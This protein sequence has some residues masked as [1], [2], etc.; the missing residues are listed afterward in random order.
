MGKDIDFKLVVTG[1]S[2]EAARVV[3]GEVDRLNRLKE[4]S[5]R[6]ASERQ[7]IAQMERRI[8]FNSLT[9]EQRI[10]RLKERQLTLEK[11][12]AKARTDGNTHRTSAISTSLA[13]TRFDLGQLISTRGARLLNETL[14]S[15]D[16]AIRE[17]AS[18]DAK[19]KRQAEEA[20]R[21]QASRDARAKREQASRDAKAKRLAEDAAARRKKLPGEATSATMDL[22]GGNLGGF[23]P[24]GLVVGTL[25]ASVAGIAYALKRGF[26]NAMEF[27][28][29]ISDMADLIGAS[30]MDVMRMIKASGQAGVRNTTVMNG[31]SS[32]AAARG[33][34]LSGDEG[35][36]QLFQRYGIGQSV[37]AGDTSN[38]EIGKAIVRS[39][40][41][42]EMLPTDRIPLGT[43]FGRRP[44]Q[45]VAALSTMGRNGETPNQRLADSLQAMDEVNTKLEYAVMKLKEASIILSANAAGLV[46]R[47]GP[48][49]LNA[50]GRT[51]P[52]AIGNMA[53]GALGNYLWPQEQTPNNWATKRRNEDTVLRSAES[54]PIPTTKGGST[55]I[56]SMAIPNGDALARIGLYRGGIDPARADI[57]RSQLE[58]LRGIR[59]EQVRTI[60]AIQ[61]NWI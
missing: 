5:R 16:Q 41:S 36:L 30:R 2:R 23:G 48:T 40:G 14:Q 9:E 54:N 51:V 4:A 15:R 35:M 28:D 18:R 44:E 19:M 34:A 20:R 27:S 24:S 17:Q 49:L 59:A 58:T 12:L 43:L 61:G 33:G 42:G 11:Q 39:L 50:I 3:D 37:L 47:F 25:A 53:I 8:R 46:K 6:M 1:E 32:L 13:R 26:Q 21:E 56:P 52:G 7:R 10:T 45:T 38:L 29:Q 57:L 60:A 55:A 22:L 31:L